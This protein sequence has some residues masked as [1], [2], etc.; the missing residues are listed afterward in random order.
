MQ[1]ASFMLLLHSEMAPI[2]DAEGYNRRDGL[3]APGA[4]IGER[5]S[6]DE[7][8]WSVPITVK[9]EVNGGPVGRT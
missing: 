2:S 8:V 3:G 7:D 9:S 4:S 1:K 5:Y 6:S